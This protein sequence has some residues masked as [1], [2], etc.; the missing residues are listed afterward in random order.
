MTNKGIPQQRIAVPDRM[1]HLPTDPLHADLPV[2]YFVGSVRDESGTLRP[3]FRCV[4]PGA[5]ERCDAGALCWICGLP[6]QGEFASVTGPMCLINRVSSEPVS[7]FDCASYA[8]AACPFLATPGRKRREKDLPSGI[9]PPPSPDTHNPRNP[10]AVLLIRMGTRPKPNDERLYE[11]RNINGVEFY[12]AGERIYGLDCLPEFQAG[13]RIIAGQASEY[14]GPVGLA[15]AL[16]RLNKA[17]G[18]LFGARDQH[19]AF[20][21]IVRTFRDVPGLGTA[22][23]ILPQL[24]N[25]QVVEITVELER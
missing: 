4:A 18:L 3:D 15:Y 20:V 16:D 13:A 8:V 9:L 17:C 12:R 11:L 19:G 5:R 7:H 10:G 6:L 14:D 23:E 1:A 24:H 21:R 25:L 22:L 2:P